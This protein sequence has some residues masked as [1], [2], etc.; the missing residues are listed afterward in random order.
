MIL[1]DTH[2]WV[3]FADD[4]DRLTEAHKNLI[5]DRRQEGLERHEV[6]VRSVLDGV[7]EDLGRLF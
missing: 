3:W 7:Y 5:T 4:N 2:V 1:L 6:R